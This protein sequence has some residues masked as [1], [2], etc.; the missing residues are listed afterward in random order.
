M[1]NKT[2]AELDVG[3]PSDTSVVHSSE[4][5]VST[6]SKGHNERDISRLQ[7]TAPAYSDSKT[8]AIDDLV[9]ESSIVYRNITAITS[10]ESFTI[11]KWAVVGGGGGSA[12]SMISNCY[13]A[14]NIVT[15]FIGTFVALTGITTEDTTA[16]DRAIYA[17]ND[18]TF[19]RLTTNVTSN[20]DDAF[21][22]ELQIDGTLSGL[23]VQ[24]AAFETGT[25][26]DT[27]NSGAATNEEQLTYKIFTTN[28]DTTDFDLSSISMEAE[29]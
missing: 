15:N 11:A 19:R 3:T 14:E 23:E 20:I 9:T 17:P 4:N 7:G 2:P 13:G 22:I 24:Y 26:Q 5:N 8:Y 28:P 12:F 29:F 27:T 16:A 25:K 6:N 1:V 18:V 10:G 21:T